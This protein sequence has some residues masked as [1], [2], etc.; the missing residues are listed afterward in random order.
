M[1]LRSTTRFLQS[2]VTKAC[3][4]RLR[5]KV[6]CGRWRIASRIGGQL[7]CP[8]PCAAGSCGC[9]MRG[10]GEGVQRDGRRAWGRC[11]CPKPAGRAGRAKPWGAVAFLLPAS[12]VPAPRGEGRKEGEQPGRK[13]TYPAG[14]ELAHVPWKGKR[15]VAFTHPSTHTRPSSP[16]AHGR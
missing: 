1:F 8:G 2:L 11:R 14:K 9:C 12:P 4:P 3:I 15:R 13:P 6:S 10:A 5:W 7:G 16:G